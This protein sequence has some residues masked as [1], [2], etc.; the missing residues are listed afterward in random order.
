MPRMAKKN[1]K[2]AVYKHP[3]VVFHCPPDLL[4]AIDAHADAEY[5]DRTKELVMV[6]TAAYRQMGLYPPRPDS[7]QSPAPGRE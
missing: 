7:P 3:R 4:A 2:P 6:L 5:R 1:R